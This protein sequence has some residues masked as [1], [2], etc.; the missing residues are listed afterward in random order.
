MQARNVTLDVR[1]ARLTKIVAPDSL[2][3][4]LA[5]GFEFLEG[6]VWLT[7]ARADLQ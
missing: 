3:E 5:G 2:L 4:S 7:N 6:L 1:D